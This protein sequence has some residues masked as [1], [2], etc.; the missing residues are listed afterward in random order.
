MFIGG[1]DPMTTED[2]FRSHFEAYGSLTDSVIVFDRITKRSRGFG[3]ITYTSEN[4]MKVIGI[5]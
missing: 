5:F 1:L 2:E 3:F 4:S